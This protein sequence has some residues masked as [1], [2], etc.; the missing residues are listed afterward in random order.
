MLNATESTYFESDDTNIHYSHIVALL[1]I[2]VSILILCVSIVNIIYSYKLRHDR[3]LGVGRF[4]T[5]ANV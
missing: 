3:N 4:D 2:V 1:L 5:R